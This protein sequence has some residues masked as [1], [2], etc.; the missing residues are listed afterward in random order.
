[1][2]HLQMK[3]PQMKFVALAAACFLASVISAQARAAPAG[4]PAAG[5]KVFAKCAACHSPNANENRVG[6]SLNGIF[7]RK[8]G[9]LPGFNYSPAMKSSGLTWTPAELDAYLANPRQKLPGI[10]MIFAGLP[11]AQ[12][13]ANL[14][15]YLGTLK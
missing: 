14:I 7:G 15:A 2:S 6:P 9:S 3:R 12:A 10:K 5:Q 4:D 1:M 13:R 8:A 11:D